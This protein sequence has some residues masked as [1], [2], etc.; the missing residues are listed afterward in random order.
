MTL[1]QTTSITKSVSSLS[2]NIQI[3]PLSP[4]KPILPKKLKKVNFYFKLSPILFSQVYHYCW[5]TDYI[6]MN[7]LHTTSHSQPFIII[8]LFNANMTENVS[9]ISVQCILENEINSPYHFK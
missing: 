4:P 2:G 1:Q 9:I 5:Y 7:E 8:I 6:R 3:Q